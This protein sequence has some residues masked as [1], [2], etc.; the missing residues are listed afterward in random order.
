MMKSWPIITSTKNGSKNIDDIESKLYHVKRTWER[1]AFEPTSPVNGWQRSRKP[2][3]ADVIPEFDR[4]T[5]L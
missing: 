5:G 3:A 4:V 2:R 1:V